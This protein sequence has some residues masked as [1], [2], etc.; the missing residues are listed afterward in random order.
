MKI[1]I[2]LLVLFT[3]I[4]LPGPDARKI[5]DTVYKQDTSRDT[6]WRAKMDVYD[7]KDPSEAKGSSSQR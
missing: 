1:L 2:A 5:M 7:K 3:L 4:N 6:T